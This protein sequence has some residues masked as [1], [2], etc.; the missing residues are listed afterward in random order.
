M[1]NNQ[2]E[3]FACST[4]QF[5]Q[6]EKHI[7]NRCNITYGNTAETVNNRKQ[8]LCKSHCKMTGSNNFPTPSQ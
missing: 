8:C 5:M 1:V 3:Y 2:L 6:S 7:F 4:P